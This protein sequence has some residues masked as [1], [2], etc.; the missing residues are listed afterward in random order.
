MYRFDLDPSSCWKI[1]LNQFSG[2]RVF[3]FLC[4]T[5]SV[6]LYTRSILVFSIFI[7]SLTHSLCVCMYRINV[8]TSEPIGPKFVAATDITTW[9]LAKVYG[10]W[11][12]DG[13]LVG[14]MDRWLVGYK[15]RWL[16]GYKDRWL[17]GYMDRW[18]VG[19]M[20]R[21]LVGYMD[22]WLV[23][24]MDRWIVRYMDRWLVGY[25]DRWLVRYMDRWLVG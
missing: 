23:G 11:Y 7:L 8:K 12:M 20:D 2:F 18:L 3:G 14:Y 19:Y 1:K 16:V 22:R 13:W 15:D 17:V 25:M 5:D 6:E 24:Y 10:R 9:H 4:F 21:W